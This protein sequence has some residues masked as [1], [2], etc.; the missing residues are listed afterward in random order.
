MSSCMVGG[1]AGAGS[2]NNTEQYSMPLLWITVKLSKHY[3]ELLTEFR[4]SLNW[5]TIVA[6]LLCSRNHTPISICLVLKKQVILIFII[7]LV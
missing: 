4:Q 5:T 7:N 6:E 1:G 3:D 2:Q